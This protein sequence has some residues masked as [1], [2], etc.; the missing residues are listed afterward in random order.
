[1]GEERWGTVGRVEV[2]KTDYNKIRSKSTRNLRET[3]L[4]W[5]CRWGFIGNFIVW[6]TEAILKEHAND[7]MEI[8]KQAVREQLDDA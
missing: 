1:L 4:F 7:F 3:I 2:N 8:L 5:L 6:E